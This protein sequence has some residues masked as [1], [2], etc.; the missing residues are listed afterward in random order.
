[1]TYDTSKASKSSITMDTVGETAEITVTYNSNKVGAEDIEETVT[2]TCVDADAT[3]GTKL[4]ARS[5]VVGQNTLS[6]S[7]K[8]YI[9]AAT[10]PVTVEENSSIDDL[11]FCAVD[12]NGDVISY[13]TYEVESS[14]DDVASANAS[15]D[16]GK[17]AQIT[18]V[19]N[20]VGEANVVVV[21]TKNGAPTT[22]TIPVEVVK[23]GVLDKITAVA[24]LPTITNAI[25]EDYSGSVTVKA[26][27]TNGTDIT[28]NDDV[29]IT[30]ETVNKETKEAQTV[31]G[32][33][34]LTG[35]TGFLTN[36]SSGKY[37]AYGAKGGQQTI[38]VN[39]S[40]NDIVKTKKVNITVK[41][42]PNTA[43]DIAANADQ[44]GAKVTYAIELDK[45]S[46]DEKNLNTTKGVATA[47]LKA[48]IGSD[49][50]GYV[51][52]AGAGKGVAIG[53]GNGTTEAIPGAK[54][55]V[56]NAGGLKFVAK[57]VGTASNGYKFTTQPKVDEAAAV[58]KNVASKDWTV[59]ADQKAKL[60][61][62]KLVV[63]PKGDTAAVSA[64]G[65]TKTLTVTPKEGTKTELD[66]ALGNFDNT[67]V[68]AGTTVSDDEVAAIKKITVGGDITLP[69]S[70]T[71]ATSITNYVAPVAAGA[72]Y[73]ANAAYD[74]NKAVSTSNYIG[75]ITYVYDPATVTDLETAKG[76]YTNAA[77]NMTAGA[78]KEEAELFEVDTTTGTVANKKIEGT[79]ITSGGL[80][81]LN[82]GKSSIK[83]NRDSFISNLAAGVKFGTKYSLTGELYNSAANITADKDALIAAVMD[84]GTESIEIDPVADAGT[85][86]YVSGDTSKDG[87]FAKTGAYSVVF[88]YKDADA[89]T[90]ES[91]MGLTV[92][93]TIYV[94]EVEVTT[95]IIDSL[96]ASNVASV[97]ETSVDMNNND[98][99]YASVDT[100]GV[101][102]KVDAAGTPTSA[103]EENNRLTVKYVGVT[104][105]G[106]LFYIP[107]NATF[108]TE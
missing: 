78:G 93:N 81:T 72:K 45:T 47:R 26:Y 27:D 52:A 1:M 64:N 71:T 62:W 18:V 63:N 25:D 3:I 58:F 53:T 32:V 66:T 73:T 19:G 40:Q 83:V 92:K 4:Y 86:F 38:E 31:D 82:V 8:F 96:T 85:A 95:R 104:E 65:T 21:A 5:S 79:A 16:T 35:A 51:R 67:M 12:D 76:D 90:K 22:Y 37:T 88:T 20:T 74:N 77:G 14:N 61:G 57:A 107:I 103:D 75:T 44:T 43:W 30:Y 100:S 98:S 7:A 42:L 36:E 94:P 60:D 46:I 29:L 80:D 15:V 69:D 97:L 84:A 87:Y 33:S 89:K 108:K 49:F 6:K 41:E 39:V 102:S 34:A 68:A 59:N 91:V 105:D 2:V 23:D 13:D 11:Y 101:W 28:E 54:A 48:M 17:F 50:A 56:T 70:A 10:G 55:S 24:T 9:G 106:I 99:P